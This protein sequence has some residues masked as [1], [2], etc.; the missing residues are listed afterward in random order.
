MK[1]NWGSTHDKSNNNIL[2]WNVHEKTKSL[3]TC[4][5]LMCN[6]N[7][8][9]FSTRQVHHAKKIKSCPGKS[10]NYVCLDA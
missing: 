4:S 8:L 7:V 2:C 3:S 1:M 9:V 6:G 10:P 5:S